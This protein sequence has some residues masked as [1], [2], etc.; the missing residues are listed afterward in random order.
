MASERARLNPIAQTGSV[1]HVL[2]P[3]H[4]RSQP[5]DAAR[6]AIR[7]LSTRKQ[8]IWVDAQASHQIPVDAASPCMP[9]ESR[10]EA[11]FASA[12]ESV[13]DLPIEPTIV[14]GRD[15]KRRATTHVTGK[16][17]MTKSSGTGRPAMSDEEQ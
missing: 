1:N 14:L 4:K 7:Y 3:K 6:E 9:K 12:S 15:W 2:K 16:R 10:A 8:V 17:A 5:V 13:A 11:F